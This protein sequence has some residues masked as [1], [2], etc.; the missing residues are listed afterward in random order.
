M[1]SM[2]EASD[3]PLAPLPHTHRPAISVSI[4]S[5]YLQQDRHPQVPRAHQA[6]GVALR[7]RRL[8]EDASTREPVNPILLLVL[9][10][11]LV[12]N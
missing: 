8:V 3:Q 10:H 4:L 9:P 6:P 11:S 2:R 5:G 12:L 7:Q 1:P